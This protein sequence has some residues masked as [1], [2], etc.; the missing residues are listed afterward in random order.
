MAP[1]S[2]VS[3]R[4]FL[5]AALLGL[6]PRARTARTL[7][8][9]RLPDLPLAVS[10]HFA[11]VS[12]GALVA[13][14]GAYFPRSLF[15][16]GIK[17]W[18]AGV[19]VLERGAREWCGGVELERP[20][21]HGASVSHGGGVVC[22][23]G[24]DGKQHVGS[25]FVLYWREERLLRE[26]LPE[27][28]R[29]CAFHGATLVD[30]TVY[31]AGGQAS[32]DATAA[33]RLFWALDLSARARRW[34]ELPPWEG[35]GRILPAMASV[36]GAIYLVGG[37]E[38]YAGTD[39]KAARRYLTDAHRYRVGSGWEAIPA[40]LR[41]V[42]AAPAAAAGSRLLIFGGDDGADAARIQELKD[43]HP[44]FSR[45]VLQFDPA[46]HAWSVAGKMPVGLVVTH[47]VRWNRGI[48]I[49]GGEDRPGHR[50]PA[51][52]RLS[53]AGFPARVRSDFPR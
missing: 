49:P 51:V 8:W 4:S 13:A 17:T 33:S 45:D 16:G 12:G 11:G 24:S 20:L 22:I 14:G 39:G 28:P 25:V 41:S 27:L 42:V 2:P 18:V 44:G 35:P 30:Q 52:L 9:D 53:G 21:A 48:V 26:A 7:R 15:A 10:G 29:P 38:L 43:A 3:R 50:S 47:A 37:A 1:F 36:D 32:P 40:P 34:R 19:T 23:G 31:V 5:G 6:A 46:R